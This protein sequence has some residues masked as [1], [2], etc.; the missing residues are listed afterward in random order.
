M[1]FTYR[2][3]WFLIIGNF[4]KIVPFLVWFQIYS[5]VIEERAVPMLHELTPKREVNLQ[6]FYST[7]G[8]VISSI[9]IATKNENLFF[10]GLVLL[11]VGGVLFFLI[12]KEILKHKI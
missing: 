8:L 10:G 12:I 4:Y 1:D 6:W 11:C 2:F 3:F 7:L 9:G 5:P